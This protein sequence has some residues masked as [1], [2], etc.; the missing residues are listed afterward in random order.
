MNNIW[1][2]DADHRQSHRNKSGLAELSDHG[3]YIVRRDDEGKPS[4][5]QNPDQLKPRD[6]S[7]AMPDPPLSW[8]TLENFVHK[9]WDLEIEKR[10]TSKFKPYYNNTDIRAVGRSTV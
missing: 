9:I 2:D 4:P 3:F 7:T 5:F 1:N 8:F 6:L 10:D